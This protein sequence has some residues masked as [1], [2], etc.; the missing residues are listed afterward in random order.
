MNENR[1][2]EECPYCDSEGCVR[3]DKYPQP[4]MWQGKQIQIERWSYRCEKCGQAFEPGWMFK[5]NLDRIRKARQEV[6]E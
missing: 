4:M 3:L 2:P 1:I 5:Q 6:E